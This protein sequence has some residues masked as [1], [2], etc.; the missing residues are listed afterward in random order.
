PIESG[1][2]LASNLMSHSTELRSKLVQGIEELESDLERLR[3]A[4]DALDHGDRSAPP[5][6]DER[7]AARRRS[8]RAPGAEIVPAGKIES[9]LADSDGVPPADRARPTTAGHEQIRLIQRG[10]EEAGPPNPGAPRRSTKWHAGPAAGAD[11]S[12]D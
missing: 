8:R 4:L 7:R 12:D 1:K 3:S 2:A 10:F 6:R 5:A 11:P 9:L